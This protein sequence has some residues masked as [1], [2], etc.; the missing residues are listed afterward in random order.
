MLLGKR[1][2]IGALLVVSLAV[3][4]FQAVYIFAKA[5]LAQVLIAYSWQQ[6]LNQNQANVPPWP[7]ADTYTAAK[8]NVPR[9]NI[10][11]YVLAGSS[12]NSL[13]FGPG[14]LI[15]SAAIGSGTSIIAGHKDTHFKF[16]QHLKKGDTITAQARDGR[17]YSYTVSDASV[18]NIHNEALSVGDNEQS[19]ILISCYPFNTVR[20]NNNLRYRIRA[21][22]SP[23]N[24][25]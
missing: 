4:S 25:A 6:Q 9:L 22:A 10:E 17:I 5:Q 20:S 14:W 15:K 16:L 18:V 23:V 13:A 1:H 11:Q 12:G 24:K 21:V 2:V 8:L 7:W 19:L 3:N